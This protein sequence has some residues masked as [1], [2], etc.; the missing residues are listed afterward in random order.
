MYAIRSYYE[1]EDYQNTPD[2]KEELEKLPRLKKDDISHEVINIDTI[3]SDISGYDF[4]KTYLYTNDIVYFGIGFNMEY[5]DKFFFEY[6]LI[7]SRMF[8]STG[9]KDK[10]YDEVRITSYNVCYT[11]L[12]RNMSI[13]NL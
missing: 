8:T 10:P 2:S 4:Y 1:L 3:K 13:I 11:K 9:Y 12:L 6:L 5:L 7:F